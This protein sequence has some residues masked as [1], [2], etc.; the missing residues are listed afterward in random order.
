VLHSA[1][2]IAST[3]PV[4]ASEGQQH[5]RRHLRSPVCRTDD[6]GVGIELIADRR[7]G[8]QEGR[9][10]LIRAP[11]TPGLAQA[12]QR[13]PRQLRYFQERQWR[14]RTSSDDG[15]A[16]HPAC[17]TTPEPDP[18]EACRV[19]RR[20]AWSSE[21]IGGLV[22]VWGSGAV[23]CQGAG[24]STFIVN[25]DPRGSIARYRT[26]RVHRTGASTAPTT[27]VPRAW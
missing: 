26:S 22:M 13:Q 16:S 21:A 17:R 3:A 27:V 23:P 18:R 14:G 20:R 4:A 12:H 6:P 2:G 5:R 1:L 10:T 7:T 24:R 9:G 25:R 15:D 19:R 11:K 8:G